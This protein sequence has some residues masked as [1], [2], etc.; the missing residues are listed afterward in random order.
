M[1][2]PLATTPAMELRE[3]AYFESYA[4]GKALQDWFEHEVIVVSHLAKLSCILDDIIEDIKVEGTTI[5]G[6]RGASAINP[7]VVALKSLMSLELSTI[8]SMRL[9]VK[10]GREKPA[11]R[12]DVSK[13]KAKETT[14][15]FDKGNLLARPD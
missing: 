8:K 4:Q 3:R 9:A 14:V 12:S 10:E 2:Q 15:T 13:R 1:L 7:K 5:I 11:K 6:S